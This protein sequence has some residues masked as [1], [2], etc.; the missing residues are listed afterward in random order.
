MN[1]PVE[2]E[3]FKK[4]NLSR[5]RFLKF[6]LAG[7][8]AAAVVGGGLTAIKRM[9]GIPH[10]EFP[11]PIR[12]DFNRIDQRNQINIFATSNALNQ[13]HPERN[14]SFNEQLKKENP[15]GFKPFHFYDTRSKFMKNP[16]RDV[17]GYSQLERAL[18]VAGFYSASQQ[19]GG[20]S[21]E[22]PNS[23]VS[24]WKQEML[25]QTRYQFNS[26]KEATLAIK[27]AAR[28]YGALRCGITKRDKRWDYEPMYDSANERELSWEKDFP[29]E[30]KTVIVILVEM[31]YHAIASAPSW[32]ADG[33]VGDAYAQAIKAA[34]QLTVFLRQLGYQA[35]ASMNDLG[36][37]APYAIAAGLG[38]GARNGS[39]ITPKHGPRIR[40]SKVYTDFEFVETDKPRT[41][42]VASFCL[43]CKRC[44]NSCPSKAITF[45]EQSWEPT[46]SSDPDYIWHAARG[47]FKFHNDA[48]KCAKFWIDNDGGCGNCIASCPYNKP[49]FWHHRLVDAQNVIAPG[50]V[51]AFM[52]EMDIFFGYGKVNDPERVRKFWKMGAKI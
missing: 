6:G 5:R 17:P 49:D 37:N 35:V 34:G 48:K 19:L 47:I 43:N 42:G 45:G 9:E 24:S 2:K 29:F 51:H 41:F 12:D 18:A 4:L 32:M 20:G 40:I 25:A 38:E 31:D 27:S 28:L 46:Y 8:G 21:M 33:T 26:P 22:A 52:R 36:V 1:Q 16:Y 23:G 3:S 15:Q 13:K 7:A 50:P 30:P 39:I 14:R 11:L 10:D 44:A